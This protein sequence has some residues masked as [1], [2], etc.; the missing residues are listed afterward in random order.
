[1]VA[2]GRMQLKPFFFF[3]SINHQNKQ[4]MH[5]L[6]FLRK[7]FNSVSYLCLVFLN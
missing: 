5:D 3:I 1:M 4:Y 6:C 2:V 7:D